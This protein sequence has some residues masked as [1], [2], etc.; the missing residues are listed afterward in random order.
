MSTCMLYTVA[1]YIQWHVI[2]SGMLYAVACYI[3]WHVIYSGMLYTVACYIQWHVKYSGMLYTTACYIQRHVIYN[4][5]LY[6][7]A[8]Y[9][10]RHVIYNC[11]LDVIS[12][13]TRLNF[14]PIIFP[15]I[16]STPQLYYCDHL[17]IIDLIG[18]QQ[19]KITVCLKLQWLYILFI[20]VHVHRR[21]TT[22]KNT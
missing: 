2:C 22:V 18:S 6:T 20:T 12:D 11:M 3:Q 17:I 8:C 9:I 10:Q 15:F 13:V 1:C 21:H 5:M 16:V 4:G 7:T 19:F 14:V